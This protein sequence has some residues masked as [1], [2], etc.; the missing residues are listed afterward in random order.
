MKCSK[1]N[2]EVEPKNYTDLIRIEE[3]H[4]HPRVLDNSK[5]LGKIIDLCRDCH[6]EK[7][8]PLIFKIV[9]KYSNRKTGKSLHWIWLY[10][11][12]ENKQKCIE[13]V[14]QFT[15]NW[16]KEDDKNTNTTTKP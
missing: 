5:G 11:P 3:H 15:L 1:C 13:E 7:L 2:F 12:F 14:Q 6:I 4:L 16:V 8:H 9:K 10:V